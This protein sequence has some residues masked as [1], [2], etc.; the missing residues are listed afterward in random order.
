MCVCELPPLSSVLCIIGDAVGHRTC[1]RLHKSQ[2]RVLT[3]H[4]HVVTLR[5]PR[6]V[7]LFSWEG[8]HGPGGK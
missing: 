3:A 5:K 4:H 6:A 1:D 7:M 2:V 8:N